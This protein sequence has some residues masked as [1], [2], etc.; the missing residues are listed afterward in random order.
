MKGKKGG[1]HVAALSSKPATMPYLIIALE[2]AAG[3]DYTIAAGGKYQVPGE[4]PDEIAKDLI[5]A[6]FAEEVKGTKKET[7]TTEAPSAKGKK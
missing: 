6:K 1:G 4:I 5:R 7:K 2:N 3:L